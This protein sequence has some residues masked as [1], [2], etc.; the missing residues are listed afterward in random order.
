[1]HDAIRYEPLQGQGHEL[2]KFGNPAILNAGFFIVRLS[3]S[4]DFEIG[5]NVS[6]EES[7]VSPVRGQFILSF[8]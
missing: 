2:F 1:M 5:R 6:C 3:V 8:V 4:R 7:T